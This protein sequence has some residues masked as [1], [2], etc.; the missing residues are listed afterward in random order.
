MLIA[1]DER[2]DGYTT[3]RLVRAAVECAELLAAAEHASAVD[4]RHMLSALLYLPTSPPSHA[5]AA[6]EELGVTVEAVAALAGSA[7]PHTGSPR[8]PPT[9][10]APMLRQ[11][12]A[13]LP[14]WAAQTGDRRVS[15]V[16]LLA[17]LLASGDPDVAPV[18][19][20]GLTADLVLMGA[21]RSC[22]R[23][24]SDDAC[25]T[26][27]RPAG[28]ANHEFLKVAPMPPK[29][30]GVS[31]EARLPVVARLSRATLPGGGSV[32]TALGMVRASRWAAMYV[33][34][35]VLLWVAVIAV[36][37]AAVG[38]K[39]WLL[40]LLPLLG[41]ALPGWAPLPVGLAAQ[42]A[43]T[44]LAPW[45]VGGIVIAWAVVGWLDLRNKLWMKRAELA[46][47]AYGFGQFR[48][49]MRRAVAPSMSQKLAKAV[50][51]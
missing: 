8:K 14:A 44:V 39:W 11:I 37:A 29:P 34:A 9:Q 20:S 36:V 17:A 48:R 27:Q 13:S 35:S 28:R 1:R 30:I 22:R 38:G 4:V 46:D 43:V 51:D 15:T 23:V 50:A 45:P 19:A 47:P 7:P 24:G 26:F 21:A 2:W 10:P 3:G 12:I 18:L 32:N 49:E 25:M 5:R 6:L 42:V 40:L 33:A 41:V 31:P 16:H